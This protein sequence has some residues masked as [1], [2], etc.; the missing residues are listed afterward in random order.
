MPKTETLNHQP[1]LIETK[2][3]NKVILI[4]FFLTI[5]LI[6][7]VIVNLGLTFLTWK[8]ATKEKIYVAHQGE[9]EIAAEKDPNFRSNQMIQETVINWLYLMWEWDAKIPGN[10]N[11]DPGIRVKGNNSF[12]Q[13][14][15]PTRVYTASYLLEI[16]FREKFLKKISEIIPSNYYQGGMTSNLKIYH[17]GNSQRI[18]DGL[19]KIDVVMTRTDVALGSEISET[20]INRT[21]YLKSILP[22]RLLLQKNEPSAFR[23]ELQS[24]LK[25]GL[26]IYK[27]EPYN[28]E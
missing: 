27:I 13:F 8:L 12:H 25:N 2:E 20:K 4:F 6:T 21:I 15:V 22:Y 11:L 28:N 10:P 23:K 16:G 17:L 19:Y 18:D 3:T 26:I 7:S 1:S 9:M 5:T 24:L 14:K